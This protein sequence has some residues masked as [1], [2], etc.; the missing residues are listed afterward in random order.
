MWLAGSREDAIAPVVATGEVVKGEEDEDD[1]DEGDENEGRGETDQNAIKIAWR[2]DGMSK[3]R[4]TVDHAPPS[5]I[6]T[7][8]REF[9]L[10]LPCHLP[11]SDLFPPLQSS[12]SH[13]ISMSYRK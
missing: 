11:S 8:K 9:P 12:S 10:N 3:F 7:P 4:T 5:L 13:H 1:D 6:S 2:Y